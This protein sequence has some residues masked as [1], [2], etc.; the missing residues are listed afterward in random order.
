[1]FEASRLKGK[2]REEFLRSA[3]AGD[4]SLRRE[5]ESLLAYDDAAATAPD[6]DREQPSAAEGSRAGAGRGAKS[7]RRERSRPEKHS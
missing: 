1:L 4:A 7:A 6:P 2:A 3:C 5:V